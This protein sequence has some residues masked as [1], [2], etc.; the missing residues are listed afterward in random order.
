MNE[1][2]LGTAFDI[3]MGPHHANLSV[4]HRCRASAILH[5]RSRRGPA[6][7]GGTGNGIWLGDCCRCAI[8]IIAKASLTVSRILALALFTIGVVSTLGSDC[9]L[10]TSAAGAPSRRITRWP[11]RATVSTLAHTRL[12][13]PESPPRNQAELLAASMQTRT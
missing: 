4:R 9:L 3:L 2:V 5:G 11:D 1:V 8:F 7:H 13:K 6:R 10:A 12:P